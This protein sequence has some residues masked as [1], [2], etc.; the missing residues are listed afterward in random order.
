M[1]I[2]VKVENYRNRKNREGFFLG[3][4]N[5]YSIF[6]IWF[7]Q[8]VKILTSKCQLFLKMHQFHEDKYIKIVDVEFFTWLCIDSSVHFEKKICHWTR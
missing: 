4:Y 6:K 3:M 7:Q 1:K 2:K 5:M 8:D